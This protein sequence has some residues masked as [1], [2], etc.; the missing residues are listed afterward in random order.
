MYILCLLEENSP[1][2]ILQ[3]HLHYNPYLINLITNMP[4]KQTINNIDYNIFAQTR[5]KIL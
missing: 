2:D 5:D 3:Y 4:E 1:S